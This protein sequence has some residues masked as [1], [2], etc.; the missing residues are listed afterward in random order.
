MAD[1]GMESLDHGGVQR[2]TGW[3]LPKSLINPHPGNGR[4]FM[5]LAELG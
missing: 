3:S 1:P 5:A 4:L 2:L